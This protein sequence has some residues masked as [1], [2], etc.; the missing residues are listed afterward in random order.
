MNTMSLGPAEQPWSLLGSPMV[1]H[2]ETRPGIWGLLLLLL[3][4]LLGI[5]HSCV[6]ISASSFHQAR[7]FI[8][9]SQ[10]EI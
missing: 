4:I 7:L 10:T 3:L 5:V 8:S 1:T 9:S 2:P 6:S